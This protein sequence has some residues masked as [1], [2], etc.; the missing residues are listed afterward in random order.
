MRSAITRV[1]RREFS[2]ELRRVLPSFG[3][4]R[5]SSLYP[6]DR[7]YRWDREH[8]AFYVRLVP[9]Q[10][11]DDFTVEVGIGTSEKAP[12]ALPVAPTAPLPLGAGFRL[13]ELVQAVG[14]EFWWHLSADRAW[15][16]IIQSAP[17]HRDE[18]PSGFAILPDDELTVPSSAGL[19]L[20]ELVR[21]AVETL[22][23][24]ALPI[25]IDSERCLAA[26]RGDA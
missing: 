4:V 17:P 24:D 19:T 9:S 12:W 13:G 8:S 6:G 10:K 5:G 2:A 22:Q 7:L 25:L 11:F 14:S 15:E 18:R 1:L 3:E 16:V 26:V 21:H 20:G 23:R